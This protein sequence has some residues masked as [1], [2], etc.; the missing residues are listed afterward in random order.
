[1]EPFMLY[2][3]HNKYNKKKWARER[4]KLEERG[5]EKYVGGCA[6]LQEA[7]RLAILGD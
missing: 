6:G 7:A 3:R 2:T 1:M 4:E 5:S